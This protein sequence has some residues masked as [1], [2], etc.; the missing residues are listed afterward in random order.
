MKGKVVIITGA[1]S[2]IGMSCAIEFAKQGAKLML[3]ARSEKK[4]REISDK[5]NSNGGNSSFIVTDVSIE[6]DCKKMVQKTISIFGQIDILINNAG[7]SMRSIF[8]NLNLSVFKKVMQVNF[9]GTV[10]CTK[11]ALPYILKSKGSIV[12]VSSIAG[13]KGLPGRTA[14]S[15]SK[16]ALQGFL[17]SLRIEN[18][19]NNLHVLIIS[20]GFTS[21]NIRRKALQGDGLEQGESPR[22]EKKMMSSKAVAV[23]MINAIK[24]KKNNQVLTA[25][26]KLTVSLNKFFPRLVDKL[27]F[28]HMSKEPDSPF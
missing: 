9:W 19:K 6:N 8:N 4:L 10:Y 15:A 28:T 2:G 13:H 16:F 26:G 17:E 27:V 12:G 18:L 20:P 11:Y 7:I 22:S 25:N 24:S 5:I 21:S 1:S 14:Y 23:H 3:A